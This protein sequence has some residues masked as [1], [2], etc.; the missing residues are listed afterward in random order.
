MVEV[1]LCHDEADLEIPGDFVKGEE[2]I[3]QAGGLTETLLFPLKRTAWF[4]SLTVGI[5]LP[6]PVKTFFRCLIATHV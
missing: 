3:C 1:E 2:I 4:L 5:S 6:I